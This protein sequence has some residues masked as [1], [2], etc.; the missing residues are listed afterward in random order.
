MIRRAKDRCEYCRLSQLGQEATFHI[1]HVIPIVAGGKTVS[2]NLALACVSCSLRKG[3]RQTYLDRKTNHEEKLFDP[4][5]DKWEAHFEWEDVRLKG[6]TSVGRVTI[7][8]LKL[9][10]KLILAIRKEELL[11]GRGL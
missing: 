3:S 5:K 10:R 7:D 2:E 4:R 8:C 1:D 6:K 9:N 11:A